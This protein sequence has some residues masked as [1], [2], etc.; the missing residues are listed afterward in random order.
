MDYDTLPDIDYLTLAL[1]SVAE[2]Y[3]SAN[4]SHAD[5]M[6][7]KKL[8]SVLAMTAY[9]NAVTV[10]AEWMIPKT[11]IRPGLLKGVTFIWHG[12]WVFQMGFVNFAIPI[13]GDYFVW[14][15]LREGHHNMMLNDVM[16]MGYFLVISFL[17]AAMAFFINM[18]VKEEAKSLLLYKTIPVKPFYDESKG[19]Q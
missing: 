16:I 4:Y 17:V 14:T 8:H 1:G 6:L 19:S 2:G 15:N 13:F 5:D 11:D 18:R 9:I 7:D 12:V 3:I 10:T